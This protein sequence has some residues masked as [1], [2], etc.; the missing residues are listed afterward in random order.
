LSWGSEEPAQQGYQSNFSQMPQQP[1]TYHAPQQRH[2]REPEQPPQQFFRPEVQPKQSPPPQQQRAYQGFEDN[3]YEKQMRLLHA[4]K[5]QSFA[6]AYLEPA[7]AKS[8]EGKGGAQRRHFR[9]TT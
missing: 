4:K 5:E 6:N 2:L 8:G 9:V 7:G 1:Q 3:Y